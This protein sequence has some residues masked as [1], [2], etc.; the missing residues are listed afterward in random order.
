M[1]KTMDGSGFVGTVA[2]SVFH[3]FF[4]FFFSHSSCV[5]VVMLS[6]LGNEVII[7]IG[8]DI[9]LCDSGISSIERSRNANDVFVCC[10]CEKNFHRYGVILTGNLLITGWHQYSRTLRFLLT[11]SLFGYINHYSNLLDS[12]RSC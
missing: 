10:A 1:K 4:F 7:V 5:S 6:M 11:T 3:F 8:L 12:T 9:I 2:F